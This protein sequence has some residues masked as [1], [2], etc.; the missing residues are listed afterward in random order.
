ML[1]ALWVRFVRFASYL[2][3]FCACSTYSA[4]VRKYPGGGGGGGGS[5]GG[6][7][8]AHTVC[9]HVCTQLHTHAYTYV[10]LRS[11]QEQPA[12]E[13][14][15]EAWL[16]DELAQ[17]LVDAYTAEPTRFSSIVKVRSANV[18]LLSTA[19]ALMRGH[20]EWLY[21]VCTD[22]RGETKNKTFYYAS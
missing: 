20:D 9:L 15:P 17:Q 5:G 22:A 7:C 13:Q 10:Q 3:A 16:P 18:Y 6:T 19:E 8:C 11:N 1:C 14:P 4:C 12:F 21:I 2:C